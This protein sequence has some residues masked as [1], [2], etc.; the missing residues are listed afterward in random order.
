[1]FSNYYFP[2]LETSRNFTATHL[3]IDSLLAGVLLSYWINFKLLLFSKFMKKYHIYILLLIPFLL[4]WTPFVEP[5]SSK[6]VMTV[7]FS[8]LFIAFTLLLGIF[9]INSRINICLNKIFSKRIVDFIAQIGFCSY[10][11]YIIHTLVN[12]SVRYVSSLLKIYLNSS[13][14]FLVT[15]IISI[16]LG[17]IL[18]HYFE[19]YFL[20]IR[21]K[22]FPSRGIT[23]ANKG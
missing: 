4:A 11:I 15:S 3:R 7:G 14:Y 16:S 22:Y 13:L 21:N 8:F 6:I 19:N 1:M 18:T 2:E 20:S 9:L 23:V 17:F 5:L 10:S 12:I